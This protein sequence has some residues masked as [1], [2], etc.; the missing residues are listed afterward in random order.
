MNTP[1]FIESCVGVLGWP[2]AP[3][4]GGGFLCGRGNLSWLSAPTLHFFWSLRLWL[5]S[6][7]SGVFRW[8]RFPLAQEAVNGLREPVRRNA[9]AAKLAGKFFAGFYQ[10]F[11]AF[12]NK[13]KFGG[14]ARVWNRETGWQYSVLAPERLNKLLDMNA[15]L[16]DFVFSADENGVLTF[17]EE[18][19]KPEAAPKI[20][21][22]KG[23]NK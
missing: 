19:F 14:S 4:G 21:N 13:Y 20:T 5:F 17:N 23:A 11:E 16:N 22:K 2:T 8:G 1:F 15:D 18:A 7:L 9:K 6:G 12:C 3:L 10:W